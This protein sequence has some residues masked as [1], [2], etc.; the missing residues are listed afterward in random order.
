MRLT[1]VPSTLAVLAF[2][3]ALLSVARA[4]DELSRPPNIVLIFCDD[5]G[6]ADIGPFGGQAPT[7]HLDRMAKEGL[8]F[9]DFYAA[10]AVCSA[11]RAALL[12]GCYPN[13]IGI[14]GALGPNSKVGIHADETTLGELLKTRDY[15]TAIYGKWHLGDAPQFLPARHGFD[16]YFGLPYSN[17]M[18]PHH[19]A[20][21]RNYPALPLIDG[22]KVVE[23]MPDQTKLTTAYTEHAVAFIERNQ[24]R[25]FFVYLAHS[26]PHV[27]LFVSDKHRGKS[28]HGLHGDVIMEIDWSVGEVLK[29]LER[30]KLDER[31]LVIFT[32]DNGPWLL[33]GDHAGSAGPLREGKA[34]AFEGGV[35]VPC[36]VRWP[37]KVPAGAVCREPAI[38]MDLFAT[39]GA[40]AGA[41]MPKDRT[42][43]GRDL[44]PLLFGAADARSPHE[45]LYFYW[46]RDLHAIRAGKWK[47]H[48]PHAY[49]Q[50]APAGGDSKPGK[51]RQLKIG[52][53][54]F[55]LE[56]DPGETS[57]VAAKHPDVVERLQAL[58]E[59]GREDLGDGRLKREGKNIRPAGRKSTS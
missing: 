42:I 52:L 36:I 49:P 22:D 5:L 48:F 1:F 37:G 46:G 56:V 15:A 50:P 53:E 9:T 40:V 6:Y 43:D 31:T 18:W 54:L 12:T 16:D 51:Y 59:R 14:Q 21:G 33:Y 44:R 8:R 47:L 25:P 26:M 17:D 11:S 41:A 28:G 32:S 24:K 13:R 3:L 10:Q 45:A 23:L 30:L 57:D 27:P 19:P 20:G 38:T 2:V 55:D 4:A 39:I 29:A 34:T 7:P 35:R 58:A